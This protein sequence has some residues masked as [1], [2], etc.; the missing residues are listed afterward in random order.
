ME[1]RLRKTHIGPWRLG[2]TV[3]KGASGRVRLAKHSGTGQLSAIKII[4]KGCGS[5]GFVSHIEREVVLMKALFHPCIVKLYDVWE[6]KSQVFLVL[7]YLEGGELFDLVA[8]LQ[9]VPEHQAVSL[10][11]QIL[12]GLSFCHLLRICHRDLKLENILLDGS[13]NAKIVDFGMAIRQPIG[14]LLRSS[15]GSPHY[16]APEVI[17]GKTYDGLKA[18]MWSSGIIL[19]GLLAGYLPFDDS[20]ITRLLQKVRRGTVDFMK[21]RFSFLA[22]H[23]LRELLQVEPEYRI[24]INKASSHPLL[25]QHGVRVPAPSFDSLN[26][27]LW[28]NLVKLEGSIVRSLK[29]LFVELSDEELMRSLTNTKYV[30][31]RHISTA[32]LTITGSLVERKSFTIFCLHIVKDMLIHSKCIAILLKRFLSHSAQ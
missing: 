1:E 26:T 9:K 18:D 14:R 22:E 5:K 16:A 7:E 24:L 20:N 17:S 23:L 19:F 21:P 30:C 3:G 12:S 29:A 27:R 15:C 31:R 13:G 6:N 4:S 8:R 2:R 28:D 32:L 10:F 25:L 11:S